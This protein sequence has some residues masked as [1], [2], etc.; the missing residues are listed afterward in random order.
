MLIVVCSLLLMLIYVIPYYYLIPLDINQDHYCMSIY[1]SN[2]CLFTLYAQYLYVTGLI[3]GR[4]IIINALLKQLLFDESINNHT[5]LLNQYN[6]TIQDLSYLYKMNRQRKF[7]N[8]KNNISIITPSSTASIPLQ[9]ITK[10]YNRKI[11][12]TKQSIPNS[13]DI[14]Y[15]I[16]WMDPFILIRKMLVIETYILI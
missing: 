11:T 5:I 15:Q 2:N 7:D 4:F 6:G 12:F 9:P 3:D 1:L 8:N 10:L 14:E 13:N 16:D